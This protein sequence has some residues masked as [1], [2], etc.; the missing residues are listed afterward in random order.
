MTAAKRAVVGWAL[1]TMV[2]ALYT[3]ILLPG[4][5]GIGRARRPPFS[6]GASSSA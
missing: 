5:G 1:A 3:Q 4:A 6:S 2:I